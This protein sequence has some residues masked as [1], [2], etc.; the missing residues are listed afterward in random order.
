ME[1]F[2]LVDD[3]SDPSRFGSYIDELRQ[4]ITARSE[5]TTIAI[6]Y[7][8]NGTVDIRRNFTVDHAQT[9]A[10]LRLPLG[11]NGMG[12]PWRHQVTAAYVAYDAAANPTPDANHRTPD[13][14]DDR[15]VACQPHSHDV[16]LYS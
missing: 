6:G 7:I 5:T 16:F 12:S 8:R 4:F 14:I 13:R 1:L 2:L 15:S 10:D 9:A 11:T 3:V